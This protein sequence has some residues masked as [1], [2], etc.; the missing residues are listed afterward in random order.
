LIL[1]D[2]AVE[3]LGIETENQRRWWRH[4]HGQPHR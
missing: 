1:T 4:G 2:K 3:R